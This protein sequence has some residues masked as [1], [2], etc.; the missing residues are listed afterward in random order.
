MEDVG[1]SKPT[2]RFGE[3]IEIWARKAEAAQTDVLHTALRVLVE[4]VTRPKN[5]G[6]HLPFLTGNLRN[7]VAV[8][9]LAPVSIDWT[10]KKFRD[11]SDA[12]NNAI[13]G[14]AV[15]QTVWIGFRAPY[16][17]LREVEHG[18][19][20]LAAQRWQQIVDEVMRAR[21]TRQ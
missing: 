13:A 11:P 2:K 19:V 21:R 18:F 3:Q 5:A 12:V 7:S 1:S 9:T 16:A 20:R 15:G 14:V 17:H 10:T 6:G 8:S 4:E